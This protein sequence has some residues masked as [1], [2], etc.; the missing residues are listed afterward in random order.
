MNRSIKRIIILN[1]KAYFLDL[2]RIS[3]SYKDHHMTKQV[4]NIK[5]IRFSKT[6]FEIYFDNIQ[7]SK[8]IHDNYIRSSSRNKF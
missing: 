8:Y 2:K 5:S 6:N 4:P 1:M 7:I 3:S